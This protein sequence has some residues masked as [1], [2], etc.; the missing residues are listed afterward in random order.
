[1]AATSCTPQR[2]VKR[3]KQEHRN[4]EPWGYPVNLSSLMAKLRVTL[5][6]RRAGDPLWR[7]GASLAQGAGTFTASLGGF[8]PSA[9]GGAVCVVESL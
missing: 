4:L 7:A 2:L 8:T 3:E 9:S 1:M 5:V 6:A